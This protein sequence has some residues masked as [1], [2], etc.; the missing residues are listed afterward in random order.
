MWLALEIQHPGMCREVLQGTSP[1]LPEP[2]SKTL[3]QV[4][5]SEIWSGGY[6]AFQLPPITWAWIHT[7]P[8]DQEDTNPDVLLWPSGSIQLTSS[9]RCPQ[10]PPSST[11][12]GQLERTVFRRWD[13]AW[14]SSKSQLLLPPSVQRSLRVLVRV[15]TSQRSPRDRLPAST[16][17]SSVK[18]FWS[19]ATQGS[20]CRAKTGP[21]ASCDRGVTKSLRRGRGSSSCVPSVRVSPGGACENAGTPKNIGHRGTDTAFIFC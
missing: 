10:L 3:L 2:K 7:H 1:D 8:S 6:L 18:T 14:H 9:E 19:L 5:F 11:V 4:E 21:Q 13:K 12:S 17:V 20:D 16:R 15:L